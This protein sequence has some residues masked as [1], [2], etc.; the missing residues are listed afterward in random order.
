MGRW[1]RWDSKSWKPA[2]EHIELIRAAIELTDH[3]EHQA[4]ITQA[5]DSEM[6]EKLR[7]H[8]RKSQSEARLNAM[9]KLARAMPALTIELD[10]LDRDPFLLSADNG[11]I[12][13]RTGELRPHRREDLITS[14]SPIA[15]DP[16]AKCPRWE[17]F[18]AEVFEPNPD[19]AVF[20]QRF[21]GLLTHRRYVGPMSTLRPRRRRERQGRVVSRY[22]KGARLVP[23]GHGSIRYV[24][25]EPLR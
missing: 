11:T 8:S 23:V 16:D 2:Q 22:P 10:Q 20:V 18:L 24:R 5:T 4:V 19:A 21:A 15:Y 17:R 3:L 25:R 7:D 6:A 9:V 14:R 12:D 1:Y 13:L